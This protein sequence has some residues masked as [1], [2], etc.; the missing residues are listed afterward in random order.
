M[1]IKQALTWISVVN[2]GDD[3]LQEA[4][5][6]GSR[7]HDPLLNDGNKHPGCRFLKITV[8]QVENLLGEVQVNT[9]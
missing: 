2:I 1:K 5:S 3:R 9:R 6:I 8:C 4:L 7:R